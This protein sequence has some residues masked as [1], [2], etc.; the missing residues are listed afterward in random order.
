MLFPTLSF[1]VFFAVVYPLYWGLFGRTRTRHLL[2]LLASY[3]FYGAWDWRFVFLLALST[4]VNWGLA[5]EI[6]RRA[7][8]RRRILLVL[9][10]V[11]NLAALGLFKYL[12]FFSE[13]V[14]S[15]FRLAG[16]TARAPLFE[17]IAPVG[18]SFFSFMAISYV[19]D[20][21]RRTTA[22]VGLLDFAVYLAFFPHLVAGPIVRVVE[23]V[24]QL[25][26]IR[27]IGRR[28]VSQAA[29]LIGQGL[30][31]KVVV[32]SYVASTIVDPVF[33][34]PSAHS[35]GEV[36]L[37]IYGY[38]VQIYADFSG[39]T[40]MA[41]GIALLLGI[42]FPDNFDRPYAATSLQSFWRRWHMTLSRW[43]R[44]YLYVSLG[45]SRRGKLA[46][47][48]NLFLTMVLGGLWHGAA[49]TFIV[50]GLIHG[51]GLAIE[52]WLRRDQTERSAAETVH[53]DDR[54]RRALIR[55]VGWLITFHVVCLAWVFFRASTLDGAFEILG[56]VATGWRA[57]VTLDPLLIVTIAGMI[58]LQL[59]PP[60][61]SGRL[62]ARF[63][64]LP[65]TA[66][67]V[68]M[69]TFLGLTVIL[70]PDG[71]APFIYYQF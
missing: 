54:V 44:D 59:L 11:L 56:Q 39:Y 21:Y 17:V 25:A 8:A 6:G 29:W 1:A 26:E 10:V 14:N 45:G 16:L 19:M 13:T 70:G 18:I 37:A 2:I 48:R 41:I 30:F 34:V 31:K 50:W 67:A 52:R 49:A 61:W 65:L 24:P 5:Y 7:D 63:A 64:R 51:I 60:D 23:F 42:R 40:D 3:L 58:A 20:V 57:G 55:C 47:Y 4:L 53:G 15:L 71:V 66:Q 9:A 62:E 38:A 12:G 27:P 46:T 69:G 32:S 36:L 28:E 43:L 68:A 33:G 35:S 22:P